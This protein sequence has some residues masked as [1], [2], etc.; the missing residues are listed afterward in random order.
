M[1]AKTK[2]EEQLEYIVSETLWMARRYANGRSTF[3]P[4][5]VNECIDLVI[6]LGV[7]GVKPVDGSSE[8]CYAKD[9][10]FRKWNPKTRQFEKEK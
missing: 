7:E 2:R 9:G 10:M 8:P 4:S 1:T 5:T 6:S 3:A